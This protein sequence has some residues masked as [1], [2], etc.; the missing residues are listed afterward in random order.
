MTG[1]NV[2]GNSL[3]VTGVPSN[4]ELVIG[5]GPSTWL[6]TKST[7]ANPIICANGSTNC[8]VGGVV[9]AVY[10]HCM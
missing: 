2:S 5:P 4:S 7:A 10:E 3:T 1:V 6:C 8:P 9:A